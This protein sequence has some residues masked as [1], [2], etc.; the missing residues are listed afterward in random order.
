MIILPGV[1]VRKIGGGGKFVPLI[2]DTQ[3]F[4]SISCCNMHKYDETTQNSSNVM[5][6]ASQSISAES[7]ENELDDDDDDS[8]ELTDDE[9]LRLITSSRTK[10]RIRFKL[11]VETRSFR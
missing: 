8:V 3:Q 4:S 9:S 11:S 5:F 6:G 10:L 7:D 1:F 2:G